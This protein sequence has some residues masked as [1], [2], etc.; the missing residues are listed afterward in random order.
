MGVSGHLPSACL[1]LPRGCETGLLSKNG[2]IRAN[3][4]LRLLG[5]VRLWPPA[6]R[7]L[8]SGLQRRSENPSLSSAGCAK[9]DSAAGL[10][11]GVRGALVPARRPAG[12]TCAHMQIWPRV[13][14]RPPGGFPRIFACLGNR[15]LRTAVTALHGQGPSA[16][17]Q[18]R[19]GQVRAAARA[20]W[21]PPPWPPPARGLL[22]VNARG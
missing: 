8:L 15:T 10:P 4:H 17:A 14:W 9:A 13:W 21:L 18:M 2:F 12:R 3:F 1:L 19:A 6:W 16:R 11:P 22:S 5:K 7:R 20:Q